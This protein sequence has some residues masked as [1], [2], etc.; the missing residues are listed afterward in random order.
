MKTI[1]FLIA[2]T[3]FALSIINY[4]YD[5]ELSIAYFAAA[6]ALYLLSWAVSIIQ[7]KKS[8]IADL[9]YL[10]KM[11]LGESAL[12]YKQYRYAIDIN[13]GLFYKAARWDAECERQRVKA[14][15]YR[16]AKKAEIEFNSML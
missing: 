13:K 9:N 6:I 7:R 14:R 5:L 15:R 2:T 10:A 1:I 16:A 4:S 3:M 8:E 12:H 11:Y